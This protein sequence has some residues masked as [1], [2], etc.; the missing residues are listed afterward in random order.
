MDTEDKPTVAEEP[1]TCGLRQRELRTL[2]MVICIKALLFL[3]G[4]QSYQVLENQ[5]VA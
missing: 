2:A 4:A 5:R 3:F 1:T